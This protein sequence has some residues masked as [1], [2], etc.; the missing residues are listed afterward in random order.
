M[1]NILYFITIILLFSA[2]YEEPTVEKKTT[3]VKEDKETLFCKHMPKTHLVETHFDKLPKWKNE[4]YKNA[5]D[6][7]IN[8]CKTK[9]T[10]KIYT[11]LCKKAKQTLDAKS[12][13]ETEFSP[14]MINKK[15]GKTEGLLTGYY[16]AEL[17][18]SLK[19]SWKYRYPIY[20]TPSDLITVDLSS[21]YPKLKNMRLRGRIEGN[22]LV[23][24][25]SRKESTGKN[26]K[27]ICYVDSKIDLFFLEIQ[28]SGRVTLNNGKTLFI[29][30]ANQ[31]GHRYRAIGRYLVKKKELK[32]KDVSLQS[33]RAWLNKNP[34]RVDEVLNY[35]KSVVYFQ[36]RDKPASGSLGLE[37][38]PSRSIAVD[39]R[40][41]PLG[42]MLYLSA[43]ID[44]KNISKIV[45]AQDTGGA[46]KGEIR[47]DM[48][49]GFGDKAMNTAGKL[50]S[51]L[52]LWVLLPKQN[53]LNNK[54]I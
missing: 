48:F 45:V 5:L 3:V 35:N 32:L 39:R 20:E 6:S 38:T 24:Y 34:S 36:K 47:A 53:R 40:Y 21:I 25:D 29:G 37:L 52:K 43:D 16:E 50:K 2:C 28:G 22:K 18:G 51:P 12:F 10:K 11:T 26:S 17:K 49:L 44:N 30:Y 54:N 9:K 14:Y 41:V 19:K 27:I 31:N 15:D 42:T 23:P 7:F 46:I 13:L 8:S 4:D 33:I 1:K